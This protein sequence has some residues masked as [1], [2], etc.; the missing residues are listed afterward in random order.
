MFSAFF[1]A[2]LPAAPVAAQERIVAVGDLHGDYDVWLDI[3]RNAGLI[4]A[5]NHWAGGHATLLQAGD[6]VDRGEDS[7]KIIRHLRSLQ[8][9]A[10]KAGGKVIVLLGN[11]EAM[12]M[13]GDLRYVDPAE[14]ASYAGSNSEALRQTAWEANGKR[15]IAEYKAKHP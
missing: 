5:K 10:S 6:I 1:L 12:N 7:L 8:K 9:E 15:F 13:T 3:A 4:D 2:M 11:H 14:L